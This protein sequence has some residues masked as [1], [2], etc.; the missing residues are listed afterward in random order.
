MSILKVQQLQHT[1]GT[2]GLDINTNG[3]VHIPGHV[4]QTIQFTSNEQNIGAGSGTTLINATFTPK[5]SGS[6]FAVWI[7]IPS[8]TASSGGYLICKCNLGTNSSPN[9][10]TEVIYV[11]ERMEGT[12]A[13]DTRGVNGHDYGTFTCSSTG[14]HYASCVVTPTNNCVIARHSAKV[15]MLIQEIAQ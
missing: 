12:G 8:C 3:S 7:A 6:K 13:Q 5:V 1:N 9:S 2:V 4:L 11:A 14:T 15:K 10:N